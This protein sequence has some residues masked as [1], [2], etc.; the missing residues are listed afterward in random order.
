MLR[1]NKPSKESLIDETTPMVSVY[2]RTPATYKWYDPKSGKEVIVTPGASAMVPEPVA[3]NWKRVSNGGVN[4]GG[5]PG[6]NET[7]SALLAT[8]ARAEAAEKALA[9][10]QA[11]LD[12]LERKSQ[13]VG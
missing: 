4:L 12:A 9:A 8:T 11:R 1:K 5:T 6:P 2:N 10:L 13:K 7:T 3:E